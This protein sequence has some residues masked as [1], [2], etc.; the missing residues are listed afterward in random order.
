MFLLISILRNRQQ[1]FN[2]I[3]WNI[4]EFIC[5]TCV[6]YGGLASRVA[7]AVREGLAELIFLF[8]TFHY[9][10]SFFWNESYLSLN[11]YIM[12]ICIVII[13]DIDAAHTVNA[14]IVSSIP[15]QG[16]EIEISQLYTQCLNIC[17]FKF[18]NKKCSLCLYR[19]ISSP[20]F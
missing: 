12:Y 2:I 18:I 14:T 11:I 20:P 8:L 3:Q 4:C 5:I 15:T 17:K 16:I 1:L 10:I 9:D 7:S 19:V 6:V 13:I